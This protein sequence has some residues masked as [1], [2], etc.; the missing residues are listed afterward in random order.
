M[1]IK[2][3]KE[4]EE[5][6]KSSVTDPEGFWA[7]IAGN[8]KWQKKWDKVL[9]WNFEEPNIKWFVNGKLN[10]TENC[11]DR[12]LPQK[13]ND[14][15]FYFEENEPGKPALKITYQDLHDNVCRLA[16]LLKSF[17]VVKGDRVC[18]YLPMVPE[19]VYALLACARIGAIHSVVFGGF[20]AQSLRDRIND[21]SCKVVLTSDGAYRGNKTIQMK[22]TVDEALDHC[23]S[24][25]K[26]LVLNRTG[27]KV[28]MLPGRDLTWE[29]H[30]NAQS[31]TCEPT[32]MDSED[33]LFIL[34]TSG[35]TGKPKGVVHTCGGYMVFTCYSFL[36]VFQYQPGQVYWCTADVG[37]ITGHSYITY[38]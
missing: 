29:S 12:H 26:V 31:S 37:W 15:A 9:D 23:P 16:N 2:T 34:Y 32:Q 17:G 13:A 1:H 6:Y 18:I 35:S 11:I 10:I 27:E 8:F 38:G 21:S 4:Y 36:N 3:F 20:S 7:D 24:L 25:E 19:A 28:N 5:A 22:A 30:V 33:P 14:V